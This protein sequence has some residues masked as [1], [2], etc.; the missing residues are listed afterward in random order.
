MGGNICGNGVVNTPFRASWT[1]PMK[2]TTPKKRATNRS[3]IAV[4][5]FGWTQSEDVLALCRT[6][7]RS[8]GLLKALPDAKNAAAKPEAKLRTRITVVMSPPPKKHTKFA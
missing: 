7:Y 3:A 1:I 4:V 5:N 8:A 2:N 6:L